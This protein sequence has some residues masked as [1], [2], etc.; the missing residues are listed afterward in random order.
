[1]R[2]SRTRDLRVD[3]WRGRAA[4]VNR[5]D[6]S[7]VYPGLRPP[8]AD[9]AARS[10]VR[11]AEERLDRICDLASGFAYTITHGADGA[12]HIE[13]VNHGI[14]HITGLSSGTRARL[15][16]A[17]VYSEDRARVEEWAR[18]IRAGS[19]SPCEHRIRDVSGGVRWVVH[20]SRATPLGD[21]ALRVDGILYDVSERKRA[22]D[23]V[24]ES[25]AR[26]RALAEHASDLIVEIDH[27]QRIVFLNR[28]LQD[29]LGYDPSDWI[30]LTIYEL[31]EQ[32]HRVHRDDVAHM[33][34]RMH[35]IEPVECVEHTRLRLRHIDG[36]WRWLEFSGST[37]MTARNTKHRV[38]VGRDV[39]GSLRRAEEQAQYAERLERE[40][41]RRTEALEH[42]NSALRRLQLRLVYA[43]RLGAAE[44][45]AAR[46][47]HAVNNPL[48][49]L[50]GTIEMEIESTAGYSPRLAQMRKL[51]HRIKDVLDNTLTLVREGN[52]KLS[53]EDPAK[54]LEEVR[55]ELSERAQRGGC[56][57]D[58]EVGTD[59]PA[60]SVD[61]ALI[62]AALV[63]LSENGLDA[64]RDA[65]GGSLL[66][67]AT[68]EDGMLRFLVKDQGP[69]IDAELK[70]RI[71]EPFFTTKSSG[72]GLGLPIAQGII[73]GHGGRL[74]LRNRPEGGTVAI[75]T[76]PLQAS[77]DFP[78]EL[79]RR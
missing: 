30:G 32:L 21:G 3:T 45:L 1:M 8:S 53:D 47:A 4:R 13:W 61:R 38:A 75:V 31:V 9:D 71:F 52:L 40:V 66:L 55:S 62:E 20:I 67:Q 24:R 44:E 23:E 15:L 16:D 63:C 37:F 69:G 41:R 12:Q 57:I 6:E 51:A 77:P 79:R 11:E 18:D 39:T 48:A 17:L 65:E 49:A 27:R 72:T 22:E 10:A 73:R 43:E 60:V 29:I 59:L 76:L 34:T 28:A 50:L 54:L 64:M 5:E 25:E 19:R 46:M 70:D 26:Y 33:V 78:I 2:N 68:V 56:R 7:A 14:E 36:G 42:A 35:A 58:V 74:T